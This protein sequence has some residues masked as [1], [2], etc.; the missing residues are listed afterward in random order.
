MSDPLSPDQ[1]L[2][3]LAADLTEYVRP[4]HGKVSVAGDPGAVVEALWD[5]PTGFRVVLHMGS[6]KDATD[7][8]KGYISTYLI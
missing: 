5:K 4:I 7:Q 2:A 8:T 6:D 1:I 3:F